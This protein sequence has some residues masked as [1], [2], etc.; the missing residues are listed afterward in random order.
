MKKRSSETGGKS[1]GEEQPFSKQSD[2]EKHFAGGERRKHNPLRCAIIRGKGGGGRG[3]G[4]E[5]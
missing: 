1:G 3:E 2:Y 4:K 5:D